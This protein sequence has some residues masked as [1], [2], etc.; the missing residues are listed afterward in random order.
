[1]SRRLSRCGKA[2]AYKRASLHRF[3]RLALRAEC[4]G[5]ALKMRLMDRA[6]P[7]CGRIK[8]LL[9]RLQKGLPF[10]N[11]LTAA[12]IRC[13]CRRD[14]AHKSEG[15]PQGV[16]LPQW[17]PPWRPNAGARPP[18]CRHERRDAPFWRERSPPECRYAV[19]ACRTGTRH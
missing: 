18:D 15:L 5:K 4:G 12:R 19:H 1:K 8:P 2:T 11:H 7:D 10:M 13:D 17:E 16:H 9:I 3:Y 6:R 14:H